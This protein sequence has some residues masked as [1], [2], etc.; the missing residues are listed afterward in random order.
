VTT[1]A[2][3][4]AGNQ[5]AINYPNSVTTSMTY[6]QMGRVLTVVTTDV[7]PPP[8]ANSHIKKSQSVPNK[9]NEVLL[10][11]DCG[12][13]QLVTPVSGPGLTGNE[14]IRVM[15]INYGT[16]PVFTGGM[17]SYSID[18]NPP[19]LQ[20]FPQPLFPGN[21]VLFAFTQPADF[22]IPGHTYQVWTRPTIVCFLS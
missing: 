8:A 6:D 1:F 9:S 19:V 7:P 21:P 3:D 13:M 4:A 12:V 16:Q 15:L 18:G 17:A 5:T 10:T 14:I 11:T 20:T 22:S 2:Y